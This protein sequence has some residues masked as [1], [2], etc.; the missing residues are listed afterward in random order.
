MNMMPAKMNDPRVDT[1][2][3]NI[4]LA[5]ALRRMNYAEIAR[6]AG[7]S[8]NAVSQFVSGRTTLTYQNMLR[9]CDVLGV[10]ISLMHQ[11]DSI[12]EG[13]IRLHK[14]LM[15][16]PAHQLQEIFDDLRN[17]GGNEPAPK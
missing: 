13:R 8:R 2:R 11:P 4:R 12:T 16:L 7:L 1:A 14:A 3:D 5:A 6:D 15:N 10:P 9:V 17:S